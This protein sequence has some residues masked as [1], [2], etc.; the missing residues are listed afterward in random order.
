MRFMDISILGWIHTLTCMIA[1][2]AGF[3]VLAMAKGTARHQRVG[4]WY[5]ITMLIGTVTA[6][7]LYAPIAGMKTGFNLFHWLAVVTLIAL[8]LAYYGA[9]RQTAALWAY[10][11][12]VGMVVSYYM[13][14]GALLNE[15][16]AR[17][18]ALQRFAGG[19]VLGMVQGTNMMLFAVVLLYFIV[20][21]GMRRSRLR[22][23]A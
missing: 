3:A 15:V 20:K 23:A 14:I 10:L 12:P 9:R 19:Q 22:V 5:L 4:R 13:L 2:P 16:F 6:F 18:D 17:A 7:G 21:V 1:L 11:H 8:G